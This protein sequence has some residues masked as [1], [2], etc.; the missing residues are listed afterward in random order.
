MKDG[1]CAKNR[2]KCS[3]G[4]ESIIRKYLKSE[5]QGK[6]II[7]NEKNQ[8]STRY[9]IISIAEIIDDRNYCVHLLPI[10][11]PIIRAISDGRGALSNSILGCEPAV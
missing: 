4:H 11:S 1:N 6:K 7:N 10:R 9:E 3:L 8:K 5:S 2:S